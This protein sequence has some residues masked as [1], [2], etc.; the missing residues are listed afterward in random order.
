[1]PSPFPGMDPF[2]EAQRWEGFHT[3]LNVHIKEAINEV[4][5]PPYAADTESRVVLSRPWGGR[6]NWRVSDVAVA[7]PQWSPSGAGADGGVAVQG[8]IETEF[9]E[10]DDL[11]EHY[12]VIR[13]TAGDEVVT[14][15][16][17][18]SP[19][20]KPGTGGGAT[21]YAR[22]RREL[23][24][25]EASLIEIDLL[26]RGRRPDFRSAL[27]PSD[28]AIFT[29][30]GWE[31]PKIRVR[32]VQLLERLPTVAVPLREGEPDVPL[33]LQRAVASVYD[34]GLYGRRLRYDEPIDPPLPAEAAVLVGAV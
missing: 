8:E 19:D 7:A 20:N 11:T 1:M 2:I 3:S 23:L 15:I 17:T 32:P 28:Y 30:R 18:L 10:S 24:A 25:S 16:E 12:V 14:V 5:P 26:R 22:K 29:Y 31:R 34:R 13:D 27:P 33:D 6:S 9:A 4:V 21:D